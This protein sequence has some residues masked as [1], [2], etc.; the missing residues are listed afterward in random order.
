[1]DSKISPNFNT[2]GVIMIST[3]LLFDAIIGNVQEKAMRE[4]KATNNEVVLYSYGIGFVYLFVILLLTD[5]LLA[6]FRFCSQVS[7]PF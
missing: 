6:G 7:C 2:F 3:A 4:Y 5:E 1:M